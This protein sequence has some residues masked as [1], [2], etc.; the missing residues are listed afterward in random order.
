MM[1]HLAFCV[2]S[3]L[4]LLLVA[5]STAFAQ[6]SAPDSH[7]GDLSIDV[8]PSVLLRGQDI[9]AIVRVRP[10]VGNRLLTVAL[11]APE[12]YSS[13]ERNLD[14]A[15]AARTFEFFFRTLPAGE[16]LLHVQVADASGRLR[17]A[18]RHLSVIGERRDMVELKRHRR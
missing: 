3:L 13:T 2:F 14:G 8:T 4:L 5:A 7:G 16:Y 17:T 11:D 18:E 10:D 15:Q 12:F 6:P 9:R 1:R